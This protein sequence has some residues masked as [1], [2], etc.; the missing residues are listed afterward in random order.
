MKPFVLSALL[1]GVF[2]VSDVEAR[3]PAI[4]PVTGISI[5]H[6]KPTNPKNDKG[7]DFSQKENQRTVANTKTETVSTMAPPQKALIKKTEDFD[8]SWAGTAVLVALLAL[9]FFLWKSIMKGLDD[10][11][12]IGEATS[13]WENNNT[14]SLAAE[15]EK[16]SS[17]QEKDQD[18]PKAS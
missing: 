15:R 1:L 3:K 9:P 17:D 14:V 10:S 4:E 11:E 16:R 18:L 5:D 8:R 2:Y 6:Y 13:G 7:F 12:Q